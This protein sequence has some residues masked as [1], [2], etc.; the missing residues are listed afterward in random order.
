MPIDTPPAR[1]P[2]MDHSLAAAGMRVL[3]T[4]LTGNVGWGVAHAALSRGA[5]VV[6][7]VR[8]PDDEAALRQ[9]LPA[10]G[11]LRLVVGDLADGEQALRLG[12]EVATLG[13][14]DHVV[15][16]VGPWW[17]KGATVEQSPDEYRRIRAAILDAQVHAA[18]AFLPLVRHRPGASYTLVTGAGGHLTIPGTGLLVVAV[19][20]VFALSRMLREDHAAD[21]VAV[22]ELLIATRVER[23]GRAGAVAA[24]VLGEA[25]LGLMRGERPAGVHRFGP[26]GWMPA[27]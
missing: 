2:A 17:Q 21:A 1:R 23:E 5:E 10:G 6:G 9:S 26:G 20:G 4:G 24:P 25:A 27:G 12:R 16:A 18:M 7:V 14:V 8:R 22:H 3:V 19:N 11:R 15:V 13:A